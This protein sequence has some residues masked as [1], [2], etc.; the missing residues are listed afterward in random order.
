MPKFSATLT[1]TFAGE[2]N[3]S[4]VRRAEFETPPGASTRKIL[5][6]AKRAL[7]LHYNF[8]CTWDAGDELRF[9]SPVACVAL[10]ID[11]LG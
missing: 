9:D 10:Y 3:Y 2:A 6:A 8:R 7:S 5:A 4:W 11:L 1:D